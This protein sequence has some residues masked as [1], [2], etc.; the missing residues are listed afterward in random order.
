MA[1]LRPRRRGKLLYIGRAFGDQARKE[2]IDN[3]ELIRS[4]ELPSKN[5]SPSLCLKIDYTNSREDLPTTRSKWKSE[6]SKTILKT[7]VSTPIGHMQPSSR[8]VKFAAKSR[9]IETRDGS[10]VVGGDGCHASRCG[11]RFGFAIAIEISKDERA[12]E[13]PESR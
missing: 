13:P 3:K 6:T 10:R 2:A 4:P 5:H 12:R 9:S 7:C 1:T 8:A 11:L